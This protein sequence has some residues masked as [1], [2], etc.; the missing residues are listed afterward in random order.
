MK[1]LALVLSLALC[2]AELSPLSL[3]AGKYYRCTLL[4]QDLIYNCMHNNTYMGFY[5]NMMRCVELVFAPACIISFSFMHRSCA[6][7]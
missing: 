5:H 6:A 2:N 1:L 4:E 7:Q 3:F